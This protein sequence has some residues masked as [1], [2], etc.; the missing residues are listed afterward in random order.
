[1]MPSLVYTYILAWLLN[2]DFTVIGTNVFSGA[3]ITL[4]GC[5]MLRPGQGAPCMSQ[6][7]SLIAT[8][9]IPYAVYK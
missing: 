2:T 5:M 4:P 9:T 1:M 8:Y 7:P 3:C 6:S